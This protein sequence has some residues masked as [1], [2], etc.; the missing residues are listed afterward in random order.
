M[1]PPHCGLR[2]LV[3]PTESSGDLVDYLR[4]CGWDA[5]VSGTNV[6]EASPRRDVSPAHARL[7]LDSYVRV[8]RAMHPNG[9]A[10][11]VG[12]PPDAARA[13]GGSRP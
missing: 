1:R 5:R 9:G 11:I 12:A 13:A 3:T 7:E 10:E 4:R 2:I 6:V 8:W